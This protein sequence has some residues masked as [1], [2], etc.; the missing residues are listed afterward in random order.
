MASL[1]AGR[2][3]Q[4]LM[5]GNSGLRRLKIWYVFLIYLLL[6]GYSFFIFSA[7]NDS[8]SC[9]C[10]FVIR[11]LFFLF[12]C[13]FSHHFVSFHEDGTK[14]M[15]TWRQMLSLMAELIRT[16]F[17]Q[18]SWLPIRH[19]MI[20][21]NVYRNR[22]WI[23]DVLIIW[24]YSIVLNRFNENANWFFQRLSQKIVSFGSFQ[25]YGV[26]CLKRR[27]SFVVFCNFF[28]FSQRLSFV[29]NE[30]HKTRWTSDWIPLTAVN[31]KFHSIYYFRKY[32]PSIEIRSQ[33]CVFS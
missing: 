27:P 13:S 7:Q 29:C 15:K 6:F 16:L 26:A 31:H 17:H 22:L 20:F 32:F 33:S 28:K 19:K 25:Q 21:L 5:R 30:L 4:S 1:G 12:F 18:Y 3:G 23:Q 9:S 14:I 24:K 8:S 10:Y 11:L 2:N